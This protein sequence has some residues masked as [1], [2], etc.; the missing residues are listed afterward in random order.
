MFQSGKRLPTEGSSE[1]LELLG[2][3]YN[4][5]LEEEDET[6][7]TSFLDLMETTWTEDKNLQIP[8]LTDI[9][10]SPLSGTS[11]ADLRNIQQEEMNTIKRELR[12]ENFNFENLSSGIKKKDQKPTKKNLKMK[13]SRKI[14][15]FCSEKIE[16]ENYPNHVLNHRQTVDQN[17][18][19]LLQGESFQERK[20]TSQ[21]RAMTDKNKN[22]IVENN[23]RNKCPICLRINIKRMSEHMKTHHLDLPRNVTEKQLQVVV[24]KIKTSSFK[25]CP[26][27]ADV[28]T[29]VRLEKREEGVYKVISGVCQ[30]CRLPCDLSEGLACS[31][32]SHWWHSHCHPG[33]TVAANI[34]PDCGQG[35]REGDQPS[36][37]ALFPCVICK[38]ARKSA[39]QL[40]NHYS[41]V[42]FKE[43][44]KAYIDTR[45][46]CRLCGSSAKNMFNH[47]GA[48][49]NMVESLVPKQ[50]SVVFK[51]LH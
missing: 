28:L 15:P 51:K 49:H 40:K 38:S 18:P 14:C 48:T 44:L 23:P 43:E 12:S 45:G 27:E 25:I 13:D 21:S 24:E 4:Y 34:C 20:K 37:Q 3:S 35:E 6:V 10:N 33:G 31:S 8:P 17:Q 29:R 7:D 19:N 26:T 39:L 36:Y 9:S 1:V 2:I 42:H 11:E 41:S 50:I 16:K 46:K 5:H 32:C 22:M 47:V 30:V